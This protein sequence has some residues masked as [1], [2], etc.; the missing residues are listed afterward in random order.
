ML[1]EVPLRAAPPFAQTL[2]RVTTFHLA[3]D[4]FVSTFPLSLPTLLVSSFEGTEREVRPRVQFA[5]PDDVKARCD[6][7]LHA[8]LLSKLRSKGN[9]LTNHLSLRFNLHNKDNKHRQSA[10][11]IEIKLPL[12]C[13]LSP[14]DGL[15]V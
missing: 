8:Q 9:R 12:K 6:H 14:G 7:P 2:S 5:K 11:C 10:R 1:R 13:K 15:S 3:M 4:L